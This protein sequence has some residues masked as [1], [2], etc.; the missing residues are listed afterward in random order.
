VLK[1]LPDLT[2]LSRAKKYQ[3]ASAAFK[4]R[5]GSAEIAVTSQQRTNKSKTF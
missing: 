2:K 3:D 4:R 5:D 1:R